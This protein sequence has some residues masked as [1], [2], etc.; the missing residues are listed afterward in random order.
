MNEKTSANLPLL[1]FS[2]EGVCSSDGVIVKASANNLSLEFSLTVLLG[3]D[4]KDGAK[5]NLLSASVTMFLE[6]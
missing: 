1:S 4:F 6:P 3:S 2:G 5:L